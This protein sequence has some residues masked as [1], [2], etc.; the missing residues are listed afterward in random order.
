M[1]KITTL[2]L[3]FLLLICFT[4]C[5]NNN[6][7]DREEYIESEYF[8][9]KQRPD[10]FLQIVD[11]TRKGNHCENLVFPSHYNGIPVIGVGL[12]VKIENV[13]FGLQEKTPIYDEYIKCKTEDSFS[14]HIAETLYVACHHLNVGVDKELLYMDNLKKVV[15]MGYLNFPGNGVKKRSDTTLDDIQND[16][17]LIVV[18]QDYFNQQVKEDYTFKQYASS[19]NIK[20]ANIE[21]Y[22]NHPTDQGLYW[23]DY[24][25]IS[26]TIFEPTDPYIAGY[27]FVGWYKEEECVN[28]WDFE[29]N[30]F[31]Y[32]QDDSNLKLYAKWEVQYEKD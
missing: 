20:T 28:K 32:D 31:E 23:I 14:N 24:E 9:F 22:K 5:S 11:L 25:N 12:A 30:M 21:F 3:V 15:Y 27:N 6:S 13:F 8:I 19:N 10:G 4:G 7:K 29:T 26:T 17:L 18:S 2:I 1:K 16:N